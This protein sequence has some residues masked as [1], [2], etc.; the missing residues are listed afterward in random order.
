MF[1]ESSSS[2]DNQYASFEAYWL[3]GEFVKGKLNPVFEK[4]G[5][6]ISDWVRKSILASF[7][8]EILPALEKVDTYRQRR[9]L[10]MASEDALTEQFWKDE[11]AKIT[12]LKKEILENNAMLL[13]P[14]A[15]ALAKRANE[16]KIELWKFY[17][18]ASLFP[19]FKA[20]IQI[21]DIESGLNNW[22]KI[23]DMASKWINIGDKM[24]RKS[25]YTDIIESL[26]PKWKPWILQMLKNGNWENTKDVDGYTTVTRSDG[27]KIGIFQLL[28]DYER[29]ISTFM[30]KNGELYKIRSELASK[31]KLPTDT[32]FFQNILPEIDFSPPNHVKWALNEFHYY[33]FM[34]FWGELLEDAIHG[35]GRDG[36]SFDA[37]ERLSRLWLWALNLFWTT[38]LWSSIVPDKFKLDALWIIAEK[39]MSV[40]N[41]L[42]KAQILAL[43]SR[44]FWARHPL[45]KKL[46]NI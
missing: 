40:G 7:L 29:N 23:T 37:S 4:Y 24:N 17:F 46:A 28:Q 32:L 38:K 9:N 30:A 11:A 20:T 27:S 45:L 43:L 25:I 14:R 42:E 5:E 16:P 44:I 31:K 12:F 35:I 8:A 3:K 33:A 26:N 13:L 22:G 19:N 18:D 6:W 10:Y 2:V 1:S 39:C 36:R 41:A 34:I 15:I 21:L